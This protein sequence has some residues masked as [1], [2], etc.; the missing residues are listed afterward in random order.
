MPAI[1]NIIPAPGSALGRLAA[2]AFDVTADQDLRRVVVAF[3]F[4][5]LGVFEVAYDG[6]GFSELYAE[7]SSAGSIMGGTRFSIAR[8]GGWPDSLSIW[9]DPVDVA[10]NEG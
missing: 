1:S 8:R 3:R 6:D 4:D 2:I 5:A 10:G 9:I 7:S